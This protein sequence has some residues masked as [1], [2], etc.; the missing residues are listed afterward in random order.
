MKRT[1]G[2]DRLIP[3]VPLGCPVIYA[4]DFFVGEGTV[5]NLSPS[6]CAVDGNPSLLPGYYLELRV[7]LPDQQPPMQVGL[8]AV[9]WIRAQRFGLEFIRIPD[10]EQRRLKHVVARHLLIQEPRAKQDS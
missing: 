4:G 7:L 3:R 2:L 8:A 6:G 9:R 1:I 10:E 5:V